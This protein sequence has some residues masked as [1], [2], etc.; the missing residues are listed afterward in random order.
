MTREEQDRGS[1]ERQPLLQNTSASHN[2]E[3]ESK[4]V[5]QFKDD[6][7][8]NPRNWPRRAKL[9]N[10]AVIAMMAILSPLASTMFTPGIEQIADGLDTTTDAVIGC[11]TGFV[12]MLGIGPLILAP[13]S[14]TFGRRMLYIICFAAFSLLQ[15]PTALSPN[16]ETLI[17]VRTVSGFFGS[18]G[19]ANGGGTI[20]DMFDSKERASVFGWYLLGPLLGPTLG[21]LFGGLIVHR[22]DWRWIFYVLAIVCATN[23]LAGFFLLRETYAPVILAT[24]KRRL[25]QEEDVTDKYSYEGE[26][27][28]PLH[29][30]M[31]HSLTR[32]LRILIQ[33][34]VM[35]MSKSDPD[36]YSSHPLMFV[37][38]R[39]LPS[40]PTSQNHIYLIMLTT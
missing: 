29:I 4:E 1:S 27:L 30:K 34:I 14:E 36:I 3:G 10:V 26:D 6:D 38:C 5:I 19:I 22:L 32:P 21:P 23:T 7:P 31:L 9:A 18:V 13:L 12:V 39:Y 25:E 28:R 24:R 33:P 37:S 20:S 15:I 8:E 40:Q 35:T 17:A 16:I 2:E 11:T